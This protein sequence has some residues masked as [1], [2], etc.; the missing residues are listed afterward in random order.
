MYWERGRRRGGCAPR[1]AAASRSIP[2]QP[3]IHVSWHEADA[4]ARWAGKRLPTEQEWEAAARGADRRARQ[5]RPARLR[6]VA[7]RRLRRRSLGLRGAPHAR[8][9]LGV[10]LLGLPRLSRAS[11]RS[12]IR[13]YSEVFF[14]DTYKVLRGGAWATRRNVVR[15]SFRNWDLPQ[16]RQIFAGLRCAKDADVIDRSTTA[17]HGRRAPD[18]GG[19]LPDGRR[20]PRRALTKPFKELSPQY[21]YD[22]RGSRAV[23]AD[24]RAARVLPDPRRAGD[25]RRATPPRSS[26]RRATRRR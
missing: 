7:R 20:R 10:D 5:P 19:P 13:E 11:R 2:T 16:R 24:H 18:A 3:V 14:G 17:D 26:P 15:P 8:R 25:P 22:E 23:R 21:F 9:R 4:F 12:P 1:W 6:A